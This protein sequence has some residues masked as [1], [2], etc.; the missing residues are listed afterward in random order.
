MTRT[1]YRTSG[2]IRDG[3]LRLRD[4]LRFV[5]AM[6]TFAE[7]EVVIMLRHATATR[8]LRAN[9]LYWSAYV[10]PLA[11]YTGYAPQEIHAYLKK[12]FVRAPR[13]VIADA[14][15]CVVDEADLEPTTTTLT[16]TEFSDY[17]RQVEGFARELGVTVG[18]DE[19]VTR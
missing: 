9:A 2:V 1:H 5:D 11:D 17:L 14:D 13:I 15:G 7:G 16:R 4:P 3:R 8:S 10:T 18:D 19:L 12:R 6:R